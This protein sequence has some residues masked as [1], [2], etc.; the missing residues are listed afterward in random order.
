MSSTMSICHCG[1]AA[2]YVHAEDCP[3]PYFGNHP[4]LVKLWERDRKAR[5]EDMMRRERERDAET[6]RGS[7]AV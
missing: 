6:G 3:Y 4:E 2:G 7:P 1:T 5:H